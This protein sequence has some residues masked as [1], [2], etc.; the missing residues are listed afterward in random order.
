M[1]G[2]LLDGSNLVFT[3]AL[4]LMLAIGA[5]E[6]AGLLLGASLSQALESVL[7]LDLDADL[8]AGLHADVPDA[9]V[10]DADVP[11][12]D[13]PDAGAAA[14]GAIGAVLGWLCFGRVPALILLVF[15][16]FSFGLAGL[17]IQSL[18]LR[19]TGGLLPGWFAAV[20]GLAMALPAVRLFGRGF[21]R[22]FPREETYVVSADS[23]V[24]QTAVITL[25]VATRGTPAEAKLRDGFGRTHYL[26]VEPEV[27]DGRL[28]SG[29]TVRLTGKAGNVFRA[30]AEPPPQRP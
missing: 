21:A 29:T 23:F 6:V 14:P 22:V 17:A 28:P 19:M 8:H 27:P 16:L 12:A 7:P 30:V 25:G 20:P 3:A 13:V 9:D 11:D 4:G 15:F 26:R 10:P 24:G 5:M 1:S 2:F 18:A